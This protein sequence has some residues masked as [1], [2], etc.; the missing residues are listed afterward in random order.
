MNLN[1]RH[2]SIVDGY[3]AF[4]GGDLANAV[5]HL[6][7]E[8]EWIE[9]DEFDAGGTYRGHEG[10]IE[11]LDRS[12]RT[13]EFIES[14]PERLVDIGKNVVVAVVRTK[15]RSR[16]QQ[17]EVDRL[18]AD[19]YTFEDMVVVQMRAFADPLEAF[20]ALGVEPAR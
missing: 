6:H 15:G 11:Y 20:L 7:P 1:R 18:I 2:Q 14:F 8:I 13:W 16:A 4:N 9:P 17:R 12:R 19:V 10:V 5:Q 3:V